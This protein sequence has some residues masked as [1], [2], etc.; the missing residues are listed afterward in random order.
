[1]PAQVGPWTRS[2]RIHQPS[3]AA[4]NGEI[5]IMKMACA[6]V[7]WN[8]APTKASPASPTAIPA[9]AAVQPAR[10]TMS[11]LWTPWMLQIQALMTTSMTTE[12]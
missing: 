1:M 5:P 12:R 11:K 2:R 8:M 9:I 7:V 3:R 6:T 4:Q 10:R